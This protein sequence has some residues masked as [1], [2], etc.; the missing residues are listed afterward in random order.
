MSIGELRI[1]S[2]H[3]RM[4]P[5]LEALERAAAAGRIPR[6]AC[7]LLAV[8]GGADS[9]AL[10]FGAVEASRETGWRLSVGHVHHGWRRR[11]ADRDLA[12]VSDHARRLGLPFFHRRRDAR[13]AASELGLS[14]EAAARHVRYAA[15]AEMARE[16]G[17]SL[18]AT[19]HQKD[20][21]VESLL[22]ARERR[23]GLAR[24]AGPRALRADGVVRLLLDVGRR[25]ILAFLAAAGS[26]TGGTP[27]TATSRSPATAFAAVSPRRARRSAPRSPSAS[28]RWPAS[29]TDSRR[30]T[31][32]ASRRRSA[33][34]R[35]R[36][37]TTP[38]RSRP[39]PS[40]R[41]RTSSC[42]SRSP[43]SPA[44]SHARAVRR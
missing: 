17:A 28:L 40:T 27:P 32:G 23:G 35:G 42:A 11:E 3:R 22:I 7:V 12:F 26:R 15:L 13:R 14:P 6:D 41:A 8:S 33:A 2:Y 10:L 36:R 20:D 9:L 21:A 24:L 1:S 4:D 44:P 25:E 30:S 18:V 19:A 16:A 34:A 29:A 39:A 5:V 43:G 37:G 38:S 31:R